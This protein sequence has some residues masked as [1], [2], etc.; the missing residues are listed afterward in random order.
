MTILNTIALESNK[1]IKINFNGADLSSDGEVLLI[2]EFA[3]KIGLIQ[4]VKKL[5]KTN[6]HANNHTHTD[7]DNLIQVI[8]QLI[9]AY[10]EDNCADELTKDPVMTAILSCFC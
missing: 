4:L 8:Y 6:D 5:F 9:A 3:A 2:K 1:K 7:P 10:F